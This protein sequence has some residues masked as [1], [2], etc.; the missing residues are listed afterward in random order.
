MLINDPK[1]DRKKSKKSVVEPPPIV[2]FPQ[3]MLTRR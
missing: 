1:R 2:G 3:R